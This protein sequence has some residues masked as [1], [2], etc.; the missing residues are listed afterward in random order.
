MVGS[1]IGV[2]RGAK[3]A[4]FPQFLEHTVILCF[5]RRFSNKIGLF[6]WNQTFCPPP[7][8]WTWLRHW[9]QPVQTEI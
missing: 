4:I 6:A 1:A 5:E 7:H 2:A 9:A 8:F 3:R